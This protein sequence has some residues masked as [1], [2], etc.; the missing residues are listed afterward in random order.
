M[1]CEDENMGVL[2]TGDSLINFEVAREIVFDA[3][4]RNVRYFN[5]R[6]YV[7]PILNLKF[8]AVRECL[9]VSLLQ[10]TFS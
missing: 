8:V 3:G 5:H 2:Q 9:C 7:L 1:L 6:I 10:R 4:A